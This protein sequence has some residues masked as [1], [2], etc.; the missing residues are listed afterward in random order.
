MPLDRIFRRQQARG[1]QLVG[2]APEIEVLHRALGEV[3]ALRD[4][5]RL[6]AALDQRARDAAQPEVD[7]ERDADRPAAD[8]DDLMTLFHEMFFWVL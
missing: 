8:D 5:L 2:D 7:R 1:A 3:L 6:G 4:A